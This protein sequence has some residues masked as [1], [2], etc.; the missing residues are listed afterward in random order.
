MTL[1]FYSGALMA[2]D[3]ARILGVNVDVKIMDSQETKNSSN[4]ASIFK[5]S[6]FKGTD[7]VIGP[8]YQSNVEA[9]AQ[10]LMK[11]SISII[12]PLSKETSAVLPNVIQT[13]PSD[14]FMKDK[15]FEFMKTD[16]TTIIGVIDTK[17]LSIRKYFSERQPSVKLV[18][19]E[20]IETTNNGIKSSLVKGKKNY[21]VMDTENTYRIKMIISTLISLQKEYD[22][23]LVILDPNPKLDSEEIKIESLAE[24]KMMYPSLGKQTTENERSYFT[25]KYRQLNMVSPNPYAVRGFDITFDALLRLSQE[26]AFKETL[27]SVTTEQFENKFAYAK[28][29]DKGFR[30]TGFYILY[31]DTDLTIKTAN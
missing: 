19:F 2:I 26:K 21:V 16:T 3:S 13:I 12:S 15:L 23:Q 6:G 17:K 28:R 10:I 30:N 24:L 8:F 5:Q 29:L 11:D 27:L 18:N 22:I 20:T 25:Q 14:E 31:Y 9:A 1:D 4:V 7:L